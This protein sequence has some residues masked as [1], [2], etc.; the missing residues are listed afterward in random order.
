[1]GRF[2]SG[3]NARGDDFVRWAYG[4]ERFLEGVG[5]DS[6]RPGRGGVPTAE[7]ALLGEMRG[8]TGPVRV[9]VVNG[10]A[11]DGWSELVAEMERLRGAME[12]ARAA[13]QIGGQRGPEPTAASVG[14]LMRNSGVE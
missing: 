1:M 14:L 8:S 7:G 10:G 12:D 6:S 2:L 4:D 13:W 3:L 5:S 9:E 11:G